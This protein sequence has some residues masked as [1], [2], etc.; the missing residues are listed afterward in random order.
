MPK[1]KIGKEVL[2]KKGS[3]IISTPKEHK[4]FEEWHSFS[5]YLC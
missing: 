5:L 2:G 3:A 1:E 4:E